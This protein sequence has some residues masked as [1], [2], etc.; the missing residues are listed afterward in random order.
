MRFRFGK[1]EPL[2]GKLKKVYRGPFEHEFPEGIVHI[3]ARMDMGPIGFRRPTLY[4]IPKEGYDEKASDVKASEQR[5]EEVENILSEY[6][7]IEIGGERFYL[8]P[9]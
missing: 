5:L 8:R 7:V 6:D 2:H 3:S 9:P 1:Y 4:F